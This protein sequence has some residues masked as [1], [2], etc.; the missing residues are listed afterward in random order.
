MGSS[1]FSGALTSFLGILVLGLSSHKI[2]INM[3][4]VRHSFLFTG[5]K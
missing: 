4:K 1:V 3:F 5:H 2:M